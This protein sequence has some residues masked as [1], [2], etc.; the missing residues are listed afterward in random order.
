MVIQFIYCDLFNVHL[1]HKAEI[2]KPKLDAFELLL[3]EIDQ[4]AETCLFNDDRMKNILAAQQLRI[5]AL[6]IDHPEKLL[7]LKN[8]II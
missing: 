4:P 7:E 2:A 6:H 8:L 1:A 5:K 3:K